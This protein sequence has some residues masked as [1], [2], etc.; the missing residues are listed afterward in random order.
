LNRAAIIKR[1]FHGTSAAFFTDVFG[2]QHDFAIV[3]A[4]KTNAL[5]KVPIKSLRDFITSIFD[6]LN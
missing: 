3:A 2:L 1:T 4:G 6:M 5:L